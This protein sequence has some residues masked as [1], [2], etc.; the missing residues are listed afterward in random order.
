MS[1]EV[2]FSDSS[3]QESSSK[4]TPDREEP[5]THP[6]GGDNGSR[7]E[8]LLL[9][10]PFFMLTL[11]S[12]IY[13]VPTPSPSITGTALKCFPIIHLLLFVLQQDVT[14]SKEEGAVTYQNKVLAGLLFSVIGDAFLVWGN[15]FF[16]VGMT[17][18]GLAQAIYI[19]AFGWDHT[20]IWLG[21]ALY[22]TAAGVLAAL[23]QEESGVFLV[24]LPLYTFL[25]ATML[26]RALDRAFP[27]SGETPTWQHRVS[28][29]GGLLFAL[30]D[31]SLGFF[32]FQLDYSHVFEQSIIMLT[33]Y[34]A[35]MLIALSVVN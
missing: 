17:F 19:S 20:R 32:K 4:M 16:L 25:L 29:A 22:G 12:F 26:W 33:Y 15:Y 31:L 9:M 11:T 3:V 30:S 28:G 7:G 10:M 24:A 2:E 1:S 5:R 21:S 6:D 8:T 13:F 18:F 27:M 34:A 14:F 23:L 35:Q